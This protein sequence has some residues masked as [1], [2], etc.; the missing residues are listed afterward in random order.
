MTKSLRTFL[1]VEIDAAVRA[2]AKELI[3][4]LTSARADVKWVESDNLHLTLQF[5]GDVPENKI[6]EVA[7]AMQR[8]AAEVESLELEIRGAGAFPNPGKPRTIWLGAKKGPTAWPCY[9]TTLPWR[10]PILV[11]RTKTAASR[12]ISRSAGFARQRTW[13]S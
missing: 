2:K 9:T 5:L 10:W 8:G 13:P 7:A 3:E 6:A 1:A 11:L 4:V 12:P